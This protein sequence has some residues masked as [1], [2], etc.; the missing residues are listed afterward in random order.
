MRKKAY[1][2]VKLVNPK[3]SPRNMN[4]CMMRYLTH[5]VGET[6]GLSVV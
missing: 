2:Q 6:K 4:E 1:G 5:C 3:I